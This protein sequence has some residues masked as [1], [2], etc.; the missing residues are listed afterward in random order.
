MASAK[1]ASQREEGYNWVMSSNSPEEARRYLA[2]LA[3]ANEFEIEELRD[4]SIEL[5][6]RQLWAL[7]SSDLVENEMQRE[8]EARTVRERWARLYRTLNA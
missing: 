5:K 6:L 2:G 8:A 3:L 4:A 7:M 1:G